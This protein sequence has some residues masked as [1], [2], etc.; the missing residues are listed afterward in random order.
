MAAVVFNYS[1]WAARFP[2]LAASVLEPQAQAIFDEA[3]YVALGNDL[4]DQ[5]SSLVASEPR[6]LA[7]FNLL[8]AHMAALELRNAQGGGS[9][10]AMVGNVASAGEGSVN[11]SL[12][13]YPVGSGKW[14]EQTQYG[15]Q[16]WQMAQPLLRMS[17]QP[18]PRPYVGVPNFGSARSW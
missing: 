14:F 10:A 9:G 7:L 2:N 1:A 8:V 5:P 4:P 13:A 15:A 12:A 16:F 3:Q 17:Y 6:R 11:V 18:G